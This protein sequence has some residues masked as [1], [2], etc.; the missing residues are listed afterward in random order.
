MEQVSWLSFLLD[1]A[2]L[3]RPQGFELMLCRSGSHKDGKNWDQA[4]KSLDSISVV[5]FIM[6]IA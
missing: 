2:G 1:D 4:R 6:R 3:C 5:D